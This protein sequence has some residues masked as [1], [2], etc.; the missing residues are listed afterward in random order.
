[1]AVHMFRH[2]FLALVAV[3]LLLGI[4]AHAFWPALLPMPDVSE[5]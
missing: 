3:S 5:L 1:M 4:P 2:A